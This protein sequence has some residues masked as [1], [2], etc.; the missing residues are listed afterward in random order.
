MIGP[1]RIKSA[2]VPF[3]AV[4]LS[5]S[6]AM[7]CSTTKVLSDGQYRL[8]SNK[9]EVLHD[10]DDIDPS[11]IL[12]YVKQQ[13]NSYFVFG[14]NPFLNVYNWQNGKGGLADRIFKKIG[15]APVVYDE[16]LVV[17]SCDNIKNHLK[18]LGY[19]DS[20]VQSRVD[21]DR[22]LAHVNYIITPGK[23]FQIDSIQFE[24]PDNPEFVAEFEA[25]SL[26]RGVR[27]GD[28]LSEKS[29]EAESARGAE[30]FRDLGY[31]DINK[32]NYFF[33]ADTLTDRTVLKYQIKDYTRNQTPEN[34]SP[35]LK[36]HIGDVS[37][38]H[39]GDVKFRDDILR[40]LNTISPG[41]LYSASA[42]NVTYNRLSSLK[43]FN[44]VSIEMTPRDSGLVDCGI[45]LSETKQ[46]GFKADLE[47]SSN[48][49]GLIGIS[50][51]LSVYHKN[52]FHGGEWLTLGFT[53]NFQFK[54]GTNIRSTEL[55]ATASLSLPRFLGLPYSI[56]KGSN[57]PRTEFKASFNYQDRPEYFRNIAG[58]SYGYTGQIG[59][60]LFYQLYPLQATFVKLYHLDEHF[61]EILERNPYMRDSYKNHL[62]AGVG[63]TIYHTTDPDIVPRTPYLYSRVSFDLSGNLL[64]AFKN[65]LNLTPDGQAKIFGVPF[66]QYVRAQVDLGKVF[67]WGREDG[68][69]LALHMVSGAGFAYGNSTA[70]PFEKQFYAGGASSMRGWQVRSLG[71][72]NSSIDESFS[73]PSQTG[74]FKLEF[75]AEYRFR[76]FWKLEGAFFA[77]AGNVWNLK[78]MPQDFISSVAADWGL[79]VRV[80]LNF[81]LLR[82]DAGFK[83]YD[84]SKDEGHRLCTPDMWFSKD[85]FAIHFGVGYPF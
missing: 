51:Q 1:D 82:L 73:I 36:Y 21:T 69:A 27:E 83:V 55:G 31:Y 4:L 38:S 63:G 68:N 53:G 5:I 48:S 62:D 3:L 29:L 34:A 70:L 85:G 46:Q 7:S 61:A 44:N 52:I 80:D 41:D 67:R 32:F 25:D 57:I 47:A 43:L 81:I 15:T 12:Q 42:I 76:M 72:G 65:C 66:T 35:V 33:V 50:P 39:S 8:A 58:L 37:I 84:P 64:S 20:Y 74:D 30:Y 40:N 2:I 22:K 78:E 14:W 6:A 23:R 60:K 26:G 56:F 13:P 24:L 9:V 11:D 59:T 18:Y 71:P 45:V 49:S 79:G 54:P 19:Y 28:F 10:S 16:G 17:S 77:E 75:D